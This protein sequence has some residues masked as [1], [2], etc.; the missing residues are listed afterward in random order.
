MADIV[1]LTVDPATRTINVPDCEKLL[2]VEF[3]E[4]A[5][6]KYFECP[7][8]VGDSIDLSKSSVYINVQNASGNASGKDRYLVE[9]FKISGDVVNFEWQPGRKVTA[10]S[11]EVA[12]N[13]C[14]MTEDGR[15]WNTTPAEGSVLKGLELLTPKELDTRGADYLGALTADATAKPE[16]ILSGRTAYANGQKVTGTYVPLDTSDATATANDIEEG[17]TVYID[18]KKVTGTL[19]VDGSLTYAVPSESDL[20]Y[21]KVT[22]PY[23]DGSYVFANVD[24][25]PSGNEKTILSG[26]RQKVDIALNASCMGNATAADVKKGKTFTSANGLKITGTHEE[27]KSSGSGIDTSDATATAGDIVKGATAYVKGSK[28]TGTLEKTSA[29]NLSGGTVSA[30]GS[31]IAVKG[32]LNNANKLIPAYGSITV[33]AASTDFGDATAAD[34]KKGKTFTSGAGLRVTGAHEEDKK[35]TDTSDATVTAADVAEGITAYGSAGTKITGSV[36]TVTSGNSDVLKD[37]TPTLTNGNVRLNYQR[38]KD[39][40]M[41]SGSWQII[42]CAGENF[43]D[44]TAAD[45]KKGKTFTSA[46]GVKITGA[47]EESTS[48]GGGTGLPDTIEAGD[49]P[50]WSVIKYRETS[51]T[52]TKELQLDMGRNV[53]FKAPKTGK[54]RFKFLGW[55]NA[56][57]GNKVLVSLSTSQSSQSNPSSG[58]AFVFLPYSN[59]ENL[60]ASMDVQLNEGEKVFFFGK[61]ASGQYGAMGAF[62][63]VYAIEVGISWDNGTGI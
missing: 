39:V 45:V 21:R 25:Y 48:G 11:G 28:I 19:P 57:S 27:A 30:S 35:G 6:R 61:T 49:T 51:S 1:Y 7:K 2:G 24:I 62:G 55:T 14:V 58:S 44:A 40:L 15:E 8:I 31:N 26:K 20:S 4:K 56:T 38:D 46:N 36:S 54:Y 41:R 23:G 22:T 47:H 18:G 43:G 10:R 16:T 5:I 37:Q 17:K 3:D 34:V 53:G 32:S 29:L 50:I 42:D 59:S 13:V 12:F 33:N 60:Y 52:S 63:K 9:N